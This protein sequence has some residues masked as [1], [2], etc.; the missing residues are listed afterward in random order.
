MIPSESLAQQLLWEHRDLTIPIDI[1]AL[2]KRLAIN[3]RRASL[4]VSGYCVIK[5]NGHKFILYSNNINNRHHSKFTIA[6]EMGHLLSP[7]HLSEYRCSATDLHNYSA[8]KPIEREANLF[9]SELLIPRRHL[10][11]KIKEYPPAFSSISALADFYETSFLA[12]AIKYVKFVDEPMLLASYSE[13]GHLAFSISSPSFPRDV[14]LT[15]CLSTRS[16]AF[17]QIAYKIS[18]NGKTRIHND[19]S[20][21]F[22]SENGKFSNVIEESYF[23][24]ATNQSI[25]LLRPTLSDDYQDIYDEGQ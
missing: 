21:W 10:L 12:T 1:R 19:P 20:I 7:H 22:S 13:D 15:N 9:A 24:A 17:D 3:I 8:N 5:P 23:I 2:C 16:S 4:D 18:L 25:S 6:H 14:C 11:S